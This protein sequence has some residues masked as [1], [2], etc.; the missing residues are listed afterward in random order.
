MMYRVAKSGVATYVE[1]RD[2][3]DFEELL[4]CISW[5]DFQADLEKEA[6]DKIDNK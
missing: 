3:W 5:L 2:H 4:D 6:Y 1:I